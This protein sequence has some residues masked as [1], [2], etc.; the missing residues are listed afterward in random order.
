[1]PIDYQVQITQNGRDGVDYFIEGDSRL[2]FYWE[3]TMGG[4]AIEVPTLEEWDGYCD[5]KRAPRAKGRRQEI[6]V[7]LANEVRRRKAKSAVIS[8]EDNWIILTFEEPWI[9]SFLRGLF[10]R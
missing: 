3:F 1:M 10:G 9:Y 7:K 8:I 5:I 2:P 6:L 4:V